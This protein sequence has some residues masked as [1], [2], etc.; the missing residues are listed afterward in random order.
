MMIEWSQGSRVHN[1]LRMLKRSM[2]YDV[3]NYEPDIRDATIKIS[4]HK[5]KRSYHYRRLLLQHHITITQIRNTTLVHV[6]LLL[7][8]YYVVNANVEQVPKWMDCTV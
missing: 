8:M 7:Q 3:E 2:Y 4:Y 5:N 6:Y 1:G